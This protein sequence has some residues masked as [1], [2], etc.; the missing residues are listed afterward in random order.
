MQRRIKTLFIAF[1]LAWIC[2]VFAESIDHKVWLV[3]LDGPVG[4]ASVDLIIRSLEDANEQGAEA[5]II[6]M[7]TPGGLDKAMRDLVQSILASEIPVITF[8]APNGA[9]AASAGTYIAYASHLA[10][11][12]P[13]TNI[14]SSTPVS[15]APQSLPSPT[16]K[17]DTEEAPPQPTDAMGKKIINDAVAYL[18][19]LAELRGRNIEWAEATVREGANLR[20][21]EALEANV[22]DLIADDLESLLSAVDGMTVEVPSGSKTLA[23][24][25][26]DIHYVE[27]D[28]RHDLLAAITDPSVAYGLLIIGLYAL[29]LEFY[30]PGLILPAMTGVIFILLGAYGLQLLPVNYAGV[31]LVVVGLVLMVAEVVTPTLGVLGVGG[32]IAFVLGSMIMFDS[33]VPGYRLPLT[34]I[35]AFSAASA[36]TVFSVVGLAVK[37]RKQKVVTGI[38]AMLGASGTVSREFTAEDD[39]FCGDV[40]A[41]G[42]MWQARSDKPLEKD[43]HVRVDAIH[44]LTLD[45]SEEQ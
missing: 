18:Q 2:P 29:M 25:S 17:P 45:V 26:A 7:N 5:L 19:S 20:A 15:I 24:E 44:G 36:I 27:S 14:G 13:A 42:E 40:W 11:M 28:W 31:A 23:T 6:R 43:T 8:V 1:L 37:A 35:A 9:R 3:D 30:N 34:I 4:P 12:A 39:T 33:E 32:F 41:F 21:S 22:I 10:V 16:P 38:E